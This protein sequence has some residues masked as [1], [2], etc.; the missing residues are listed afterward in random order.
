MHFPTEVALFVVPRHYDRSMAYLDPE[1]QRAAVRRYYEKNKHI[2]LEKNKRKVQRMKVFIPQSKEV[3]CADCGKSYPYYVM[4]FDHREN[5]EAQV[6]KLVHFGSWKRLLREMEK[7]DVVCANCH[8]IR[9]W[10][11][12]IKSG[13]LN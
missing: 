2:Y 8:R 11:G 9:T 5:K 6:G 1:K 7:C 4:D 3:P 13:L 12:E 10:G